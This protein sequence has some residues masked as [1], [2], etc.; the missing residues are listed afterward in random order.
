MTIFCQNFKKHKNSKPVECEEVGTSFSQ[1]TVFIC[2]EC[3]EK[4]DVIEP[5]LNASWGEVGTRAGYPKS[6]LRK[7]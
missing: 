6:M 4:M 7:L 1:I 5:A 3:H 2:P